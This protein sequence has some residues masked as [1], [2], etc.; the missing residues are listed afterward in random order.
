MKMNRQLNVILAVVSTLA[1]FGAACAGSLRHKAIAADSA[2]YTSL[3]AIQVT[4]DQLC[5]NKSTAPA[6]IACTGVISTAQR[7]EIAKY[8]LPAL[9]AGKDLNSVIKVWQPGT[10][11]PAEIATII[12]KIKQ[13]VDNV[14][15]NWPNA[16]A[17]AQL[18]GKVLEA[19]S[20]VLKL[21][22]G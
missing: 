19:Q 18:Q 13:L 20:A 4:A 17:K 11:A 14:L 8:L 22:Q 6:P 21:L 9:Q 12:G 10:P 15:A 1:L 7:I 2:V 3:T 16:D 5:A